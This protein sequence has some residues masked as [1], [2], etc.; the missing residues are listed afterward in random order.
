MK[1]FQHVAT[2]EAK[3]HGSIII[4][5]NEKSCSFALLFLFLF[6]CLFFRYTVSWQWS[7]LLFQAEADD[8][9]GERKTTHF[10]QVTSVQSL[11]DMKQSP[12]TVKLVFTCTSVPTYQFGKFQMV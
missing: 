3:V 4:M 9:Y 2:S 6:V 11:Y 8:A 1:N 5:V 10:R 12:R 7:L